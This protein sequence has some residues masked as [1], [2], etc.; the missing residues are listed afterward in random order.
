MMM[1]M[2]I[3]AYIPSVIDLQNETVLYPG[4]FQRSSRLCLK[5][6]SDLDNSTFSLVIS[7]T[8]NSYRK[9]IFPYIMFERE[10][11]I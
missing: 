2:M 5:T 7:N 4:F 10:V 6:D 11:T 1:M 9:R 3:F 8:W